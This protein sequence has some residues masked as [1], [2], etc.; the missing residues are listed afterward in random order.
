MDPP[1]QGDRRGGDDAS[2]RPHAP[3]EAS[4]PAV[5]PP[6]HRPPV[7][8]A[9]AVATTTSS[10]ESGEGAADHGRPN[11]KLAES[12]LLPS[13]KDQAQS[14]RHRG[15]DVVLAYSDH[16]Q[17]QDGEPR[18]R[19]LPTAVA[20]QPAPPP[21]PAGSNNNAFHLLRAMGT[22][23]N[24]PVSDKINAAV[25]SLG[26]SCQ[27]VS[28]DDV[29]RD[30]AAY[31]TIRSD[32]GNLT[33]TY[34]RERTGRPIYTCRPDNWNETLGH[35]SADEIAIVVGNHVRPKNNQ[36]PV[37]LRVV[38]LKDFLVSAGVYSNYVGVDA[39]TNLYEAKLDHKVSIRFQTAFIPVEQNGAVEFCSEWYNYNTTNKRIPAMLS[40]YA[41]LKASRSSKTAAIQSSFC[42]MQ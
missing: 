8:A 36:D 35:V 4:R 34:L 27:I 11:R 40:F 2:S 6:R 37:H 32:R 13:F 20:L 25:G 21:P 19:N 3:Q 15:R 30:H 31:G 42:I 41:P 39:E 9:T 26:Y 5:S 22:A 1:E 18:S 38:T 33:D 16:Q 28:W 7:V 14:S 29:E 23:A 17:Q 10:Q 12:R 24:D